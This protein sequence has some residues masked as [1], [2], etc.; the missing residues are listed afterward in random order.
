[1][2]MDVKYAARKEQLES[3]LAELKGRLTEIEEELDEPASRDAE[4]R[5]VERED[6]EVL[7]RLG[8]A[9]QKEVRAIELALQRIERGDYGV[10]DTCGAEITD[11]RLEILPYTVK[12]RDCARAAE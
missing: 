9:G 5:A 7:E 10:C 3:R 1:M 11:E 4:E 12:C 2:T 6:D 8:L